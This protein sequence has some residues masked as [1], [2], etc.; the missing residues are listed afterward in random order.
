[1]TREL[2]RWRRYLRFWGPDPVA[3]VADEFGF[4]VQERI[5][6]LVARGMD[7]QA[8]REQALRGF[9]D[10]E[11][12]TTTC[13]DLAWEKESAMRR[14]DWLDAIRQDVLLSLR[15]MRSQLSLTLAAVFTLALGIGGTTAI[16]SVVNTV[17][18]RP[19]PYRDADRLVIIWETF[20]EFQQG[21]ASPAH[22]YDWKE[23]SRVLETAGVWG[24]RT[25]NITSDGDPE[26]G[27]ASGISCCGVDAGTIARSCQ[28]RG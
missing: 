12:V 18:L 24:A 20:R 8:A 2:P 15:Q 17:L 14:S 19:L 22:Y 4:H 10:I 16:F 9:G 11:H 7:E 27:R 21:R 23:Q 26:R 25:F 3:D 28:R 1:M 13:R 5:D 6:E